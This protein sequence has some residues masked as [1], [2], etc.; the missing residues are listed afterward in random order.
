[1]VVELPS[2]EIEKGITATVDNRLKEV[3][4]LITRFVSGEPEREIVFVPFEKLDEID[5][6]REVVEW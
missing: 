2:V 4:I 5:R 6:L 1:M 3:R